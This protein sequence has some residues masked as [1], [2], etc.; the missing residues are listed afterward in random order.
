MAVTERQ[1]LVGREQAAPLNQIGRAIEADWSNFIKS[2]TKGQSNGAAAPS[3]SASP[4]ATTAV[5][6]LAPR[7]SSGC[8]GAELSRLA[9]HAAECLLAL[10]TAKEAYASALKAAAARA[11]EAAAKSARRAAAEE[12]FRMAEE[13]EAA[14]AVEA[15]AATAV[16]GCAEAAGEGED[17]VIFRSSPKALE[18]ARAA[19]ASSQL[20][21]AMLERILYEKNEAERLGYRSC[22]YSYTSRTLGVDSLA[23]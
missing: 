3:P 23:H 18:E 15:A 2:P 13:A 12:E 19:H 21:A 10:S 17:A 1:L 4:A 11:E 16:V 7:L 22:R 9:T 14:A 20:E 5:A 8:G 6:G